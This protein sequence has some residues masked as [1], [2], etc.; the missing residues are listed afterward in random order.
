MKLYR[1]SG[2]LLVAIG[3]IH[4]LIGLT[5]GWEILQGIVAEGGWN[6]IEPGGQ[7]HYARSAILWFL[8]I[9]FFWLLL[10]YLMQ[11]WLRNFALPLPTSIGWGLLLAGVVVVF[12]LPVSGAWLFIPLGILVILGRPQ[13]QHKTV[14]L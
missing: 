13:Q 5:M 4:N 11:C 8:L 6:T 12:V 1:N 3:V 9:G 14:A 7:I 2:W 10:G